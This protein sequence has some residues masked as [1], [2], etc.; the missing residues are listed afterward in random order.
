[1]ELN[2]SAAAA[3]GAAFGLAAALKCAAAPRAVPTPGAVA[4]PQVEHWGMKG[5]L[6]VVT[7]GANGIG[8]AVALE[9]ARQGAM[10]I[11]G[12]IDENE[13]ATLAAEAQPLAGEVKFVKADMSDAAVP[14]QLI[15]AAMKWQG[16]APV[17]VLVNN[18]GIQADNGKPVHLL[19]ESIWDAVM[20]VNLKSY[21][22][23]SKSA[24]PGMLKAKAGVIIHIASVQG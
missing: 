2:V 7:G 15:G 10:V 12:D 1:M 4:S 22:L 24:L 18:V 8:R 21:F 23:T 9:F 16:G 13:G 5:K 14:G 19:D 6:V 17:S 20:N 11:A 3:F